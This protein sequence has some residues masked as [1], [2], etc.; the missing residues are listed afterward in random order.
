[1][2]ERTTLRSFQLLQNPTDQHLPFSV[3]RDQINGHRLRMDMAFRCLKIRFFQILGYLL[4]LN[5]SGHIS[6]RTRQLERKN[7]K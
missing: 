5:K 4:E 3:R 7:V 2:A 6:L 1:M